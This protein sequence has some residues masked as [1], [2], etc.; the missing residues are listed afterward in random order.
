MSNAISFEIRN[1]KR[2]KRKLFQDEFESFVPYIHQHETF[3]WT[4]TVGRFLGM[5]N[6]EPAPNCS[7]QIAWD[8]ASDIH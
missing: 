8:L 6:L 7:R 3:S 2:K 4:I 5:D 1:K